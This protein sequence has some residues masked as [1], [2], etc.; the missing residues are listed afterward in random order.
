MKKSDLKTKAAFY[1]KTVEWSEEDGCF[2]GSAPPLIGPCCHGKN[3]ARV[4]AQLC[5]IVEEWIALLEGDGHKLPAPLAAKDFSGKFVLRIPRTLHRTLER[6]ARK[7]GVSLNQYVL[8][9]LSERHHFGAS[10]EKIELA[11]D[12]LAHPKESRISDWLGPQRY[13]H[14]RVVVSG[15]TTGGT[16]SQFLGAISPPTKSYRGPHRVRGCGGYAH[17]H[18]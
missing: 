1:T 15:T 4:H 8:Y 18:R 2:V 10:Q 13:S 7:Q 11:L 14:L 16:D 17:G 9:I 3:E 6:E 12:R 5:E